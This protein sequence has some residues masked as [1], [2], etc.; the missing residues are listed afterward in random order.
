MPCD[1]TDYDPKGNGVSAWD[2]TSPE[3]A[4]T[5]AVTVFGACAV[6]KTLDRVRETLFSGGYDDHRFWIAALAMILANAHKQHR[7][8]FDARI[9]SRPTSAAE[10]SRSD[11]SRPA[12]SG[13][14]ARPLASA[15]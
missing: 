3:E 4:A 5:V 10:V 14:A 9:G 6:T 7:S 1:V 12:H 13:H 8:G 2:V 11:G 15:G